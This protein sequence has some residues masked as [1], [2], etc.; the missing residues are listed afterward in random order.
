MGLWERLHYALLSPIGSIFFGL[1]L[2]LTLLTMAYWLL[3]LR[4]RRRDYYAYRHQAHYKTAESR[5]KGLV[6]VGPH[7][8]E[9]FGRQSAVQFPDG[10]YGLCLLPPPELASPIIQNRFHT[11][12]HAISG[13]PVFAPYADFIDKESLVIVQKGSLQPRRRGRRPIN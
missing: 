4:Q 7:K 9:F 13:L 5:A 8:T 11:L 6:F 12:R 3:C 1:L 2:F 10:S